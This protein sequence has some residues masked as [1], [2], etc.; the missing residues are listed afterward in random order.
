MALEEEWETYQKELPSM[1][2][3]EGK[4]VL[5]HG[6]QVVDFFVSYEDALKAGYSQFS[7]QPF[8]VKQIEMV[9]RVHFINRFVPRTDPA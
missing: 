5:I 1:S 7:V 4:Y 3:Q 8:L 2:P 6:S 9:E